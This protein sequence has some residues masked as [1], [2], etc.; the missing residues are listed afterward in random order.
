VYADK[1]I[2]ELSTYQQANSNLPIPKPT[3]DP[4]HPID[5]STWE[6]WFDP[7][8]GRPKL[9][10]EQFHGEVFRRVRFIVSVTNKVVGMIP[11]LHSGIHACREEESVAVFARRYPLGR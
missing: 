11:L 10:L 6:S 9:A 3:R 1:N 7:V 4:R 2:R 8:T 5:D